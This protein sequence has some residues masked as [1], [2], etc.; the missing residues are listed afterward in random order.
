MAFWSYLE[1]MSA[2]SDE[3]HLLSHKNWFEIIVCCKSIPKSHAFRVDEANQ[4]DLECCREMAFWSYRSMSARKRYEKHHWVIR[5]PFGT[6]IVVKVFQVAAFRSD[7]PT[8]QILS[9]A[10]K[11]RFRL[12]IDKWSQTIWKASVESANWFEIMSLLPEYP[13]SCVPGVDRSLPFVLSVAEKWRFGLQIG[14]C[15]QTCQ[16]SI[17]WVT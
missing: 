15:T 14:E 6:I 9:V 12:Q 3:K 2:R 17:C 4:P 5:I 1:S 16:K 13:K 8:I 11:W 7:K 10:V